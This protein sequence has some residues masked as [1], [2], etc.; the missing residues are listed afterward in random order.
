[1]THRHYDTQ[2]GFPEEAPQK[3]TFVR[4]VQGGWSVP[5]SVVKGDKHATVA[6]RQDVAFVRDD[7]VDD[8][9]G[10]DDQLVKS[11]GIRRHGVIALDGNGWMREREE[12]I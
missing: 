11:F 10:L 2:Q 4:E 1:M 3:A 8:A 12:T 7:F 5:V 9:I 6:D